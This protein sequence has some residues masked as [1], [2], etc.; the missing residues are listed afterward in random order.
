MSEPA[1][2]RA[3]PISLV[4]SPP[5]GF[6]S[7]CPF[8][9]CPRFQG[10]EPSKVARLCGFKS[11]EMHAHKLKQNAKHTLLRASTYTAAADRIQV[12]QE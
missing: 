6:A 3:S 11:S 1:S 2:H 12:V 4:L 5:T 8:L 10:M 9:S 7:G